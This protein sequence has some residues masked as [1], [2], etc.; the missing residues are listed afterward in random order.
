MTLGNPVEPLLQIPLM[1]GETAGGTGSPEW[2]CADAAIV[3]RVCVSNVTAGPMISSNLARSHS[4]R[5][6]RIGTGTA[7]TFQ[8][9]RLASTRS[10]EFG[11]A[12]TM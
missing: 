2:F 10:T 7:P 12:S 1:D 6:Q 4:G 3:S 5:S 8:H 11:I 9:P